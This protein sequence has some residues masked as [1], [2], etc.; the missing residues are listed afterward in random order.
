MRSNAI[1]P[2]EQDIL[3]SVEKGEWQSVSNVAEEIKR[4]QAY[5]AAANMSF[6]KET[7]CALGDN[8]SA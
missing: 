1:D 7:F 4:Y 2:E 5:A 8:S 6:S 3:E